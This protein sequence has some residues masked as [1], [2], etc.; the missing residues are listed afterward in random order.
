MTGSS[1]SAPVLEADGLRIPQADAGD[2]QAAVR[3]AEA[4][5][6]AGLPTHER[7]EVLDRAAELLV[8]RRDD[9]AWTVCREVDKPIALAEGEI[10][11]AVG[12]LRFAAAEARHLAGRAVTIDAAANGLGKIGYTQR[13]PLGVLGAITPFN[14]PVNLVA[15]K[16]A[17]AIAAGC[18]AILKPAPQAPLSALGLA[19]VFADAGLPEGW[20]SVLPGPA[21]EVG[22]AIVDHPDV[23]VIS[24]TGSA[25][26]GW[27]LAEQAPRKKVLLELGGSAP[28]IVAADARLDLAASRLAANATAY[29]GQ[30]CISVQRIYVEEAVE[31]EF[32]PRLLA[33]V[34]A[35]EVGAPEDPAVACGPVIDDAAADR[36]AQWIEEAVRAGARVLA[37]GEVS[38]RLVSPTVLA[39]VPH[40][41]KLIQEEAFGPVVCVQRVGSVG[42]AIERANGTRFALQAAVFTESL[43]TA[44][45][46]AQE[47]R[48]GGVLVNEAPTFRADHA[49]YGGR[50][51]SG[52]TR[53]GPSAVVRELTDERLV[54]IDLPPRG[55]AR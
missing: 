49:P 46:A 12:T 20:L 39:D 23:P 6:S 29:A 22:A 1:E 54:V 51:D 17:P 27:G 34:S 50:G 7:A 10:D 30:S 43:A 40:E 21:E 25:R 11:R 38:G 24:F 14:F 44:M 37:G 36:L 15:H 33:A 3:A 42:E 18:P 26:V 16:L 47:L 31:A 55:D 52:N 45:R 5:L 53:E 41:A 19:Q 4:A 2:V 9:L 13:I 35:V 48:F 32:V 28:A 8:G